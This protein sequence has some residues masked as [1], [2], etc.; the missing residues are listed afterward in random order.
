[1]TSISMLESAA[2]TQRFTP[3]PNGIQANG[4]GFA[5][6]NRSGLND[7]ASGK[8]SSNRWASWI[9]IISVVPSGMTQSPSRI[10]FVG[11]RIV[12][13]RTGRVRSTSQIVA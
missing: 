7:S 2:P 13:L 8:F 5:P 12:A 6:T 11:V 9:L 1:M 4:F 10:R 3:P